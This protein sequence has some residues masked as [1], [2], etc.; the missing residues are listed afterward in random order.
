ML[1]VPQSSSK[2]MIPISF[3]YTPTDRDK[4]VRGKKGASVFFKKKRMTM[5]IST[6]LELQKADNNSIK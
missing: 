2:S 5:K 3:E 4:R 6:A 1:E